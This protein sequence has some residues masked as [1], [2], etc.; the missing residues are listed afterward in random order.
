MALTPFTLA[1]AFTAGLLALLSPCSF[2]LL[3]G[4]LAYHYAEVSRPKALMSGIASLL[5]VVGVFSAIGGLAVLLGSF[6]SEFFPYF[7]VAAGVLILVLGVKTLL[8]GYIPG[9]SFLTKGLKWHR[10]WGFFL[11][12]I[13]YGFGSA[14]CTAPLFLSVLVYAATTSSLQ[15]GIFILLIY[16]VGLGLPLLILGI[17][18]AETRGVLLKKAMK[19]LPHIQKATGLLLIALGVY[20][21][22]F[23]FT[24]L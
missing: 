9:F 12:G 10:V 23:Y 3:P 20:L 16:S 6:A 14:G 15:E 19:L 2:P 4:Y 8:G 24:S 5:G 1:F 13:A 11:F 17:L 22:A 21:V 18:A 7:E